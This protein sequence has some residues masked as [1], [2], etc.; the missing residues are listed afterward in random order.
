L[1]FGTLVWGEEKA[2]ANKEKRISQL[3]PACFP[4]QLGF[5]HKI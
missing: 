1:E 5:L 2:R 3:L 4:S